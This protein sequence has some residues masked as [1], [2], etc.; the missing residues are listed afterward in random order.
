M[1]I[2]TALKSS[3]V[4]RGHKS[5]PT[6]STL[7]VPRPPHSPFLP[8][9]LLRSLTPT[10]VEAGSPLIDEGCRPLIPLI[11]WTLGHL[12]LWLPRRRFLLRACAHYITGR[13]EGHLLATHRT[14]A[15]PHHRR[16]APHR[17][18]AMSIGPLQCACSSS[19]ALCFRRLL[20]K[21]HLHYLL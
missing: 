8:P 9:P 1:K 7:V 20:W 3:E 12:A 14:T 5:S 19:L 13:R 16:N 10:V 4:N 6:S 17:T 21:T 11:K 18:A 15:A 2:W